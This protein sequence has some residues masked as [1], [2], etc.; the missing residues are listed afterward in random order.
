VFS[1]NGRWIAYSSNVSG[2]FQIIVQTF[3][4]P[5]GEKWPIST[6]GGI[7]RRW[8]RDGHELYYIDLEQHMVA[9]SVPTEGNFQAGKSVNLFDTPFGIMTGFVGS[10]FNY[11]AAV[12]GQ[13]FLM[14]V[15]H[16]SLTSTPVLPLTVTLNWMP[17]SK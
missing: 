2:T 12:G 4:D 6:N 14:A 15:P 9:V 7:Y 5:S 13:R 17:T 1:P 16:Q 8:P 11:D 3:P 10:T